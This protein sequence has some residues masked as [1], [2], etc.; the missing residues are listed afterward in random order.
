MAV[1]R[2][3]GNKM[4]QHL[5]L[6]ESPNIYPNWNFWFENILSGNPA[7]WYFCRIVSSREIL[8]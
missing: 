5:A 3:N 8:F 7:K 1:D 2:P 4:N 6:Q